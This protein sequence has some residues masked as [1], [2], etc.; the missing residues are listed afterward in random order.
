MNEGEAPGKVPQP[1]P[2]N[3]PNDSTSPQ[4][5]FRQAVDAI[6]EWARRRERDASAIR[7]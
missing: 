1:D 7:R 5:R 4:A 3:H 6:I 2:T